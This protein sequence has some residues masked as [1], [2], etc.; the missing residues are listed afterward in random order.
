L[1]ALEETYPRDMEHEVLLGKYVKKFL[2]FEICPF[3][4]AEVEAQM[5]PFEPF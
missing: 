4:E 5:K 2:T 3:N 1:K